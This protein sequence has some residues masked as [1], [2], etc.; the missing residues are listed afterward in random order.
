MDWYTE[1]SGECSGPCI[2]FN[3]RPVWVLVSPDSVK[4]GKAWRKDI[5]LIAFFWRLLEVLGD[6][7]QS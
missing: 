4:C 5:A 6:G 2:L 7:Y 3:Q 1:G